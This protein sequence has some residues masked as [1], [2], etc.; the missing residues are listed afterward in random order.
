MDDL[1]KIDGNGEDLPASLQHLLVFLQL[2]LVLFLELL[3]VPR[4]VVGAFKHRLELTLCGPAR[5]LE[6]H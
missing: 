6:R 3:L 1:E 4:L 2:R 5:L